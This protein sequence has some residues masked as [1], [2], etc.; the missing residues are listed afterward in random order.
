MRGVLPACAFVCPDTYRHLKVQDAHYCRVLYCHVALAPAT[1]AA[2]SPTAATDASG[3][4][5]HVSLPSDP[6]ALIKILAVL[7]VCLAAAA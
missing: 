7:S 2:A 6:V 3:H 4:C 1:V 5:L